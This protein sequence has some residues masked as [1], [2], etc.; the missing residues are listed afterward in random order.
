MLEKA[1][2]KSWEE[3][4]RAM[5]FTPLGMESAGFGA[6]AT[7]GR[8][9]QPWGHAK[10]LLSGIKAVSPGPRADNPAAIGPA[11][12]VHCSLPDLA[13]YV[14]FHLTGEEGASKLLKAEAFRKLHT[15][16]GADYALGWIVLEREWAGGRALMHNGSNTMFYAVVWMAPD[17]DCAVIVAT[18]VGVNAAAAGCDEA[19]A[20]LI[21]KFFSN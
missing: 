5:L 20:K 11:G 19:A 1:A 12:T 4:M 16:A 3:L 17:R 6:P 18:N 15:S 2:G 10:G 21:Q 8:V 7:L 9:D 14:V 13:R